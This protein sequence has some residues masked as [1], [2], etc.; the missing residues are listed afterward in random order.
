MRFRA[1]YVTDTEIDELVHRCTPGLAIEPDAGAVLPFP[2]PNNGDDQDGHDQ[3]DS[4][5]GVAS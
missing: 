5:G 2:H 4:E 3:H 1:G